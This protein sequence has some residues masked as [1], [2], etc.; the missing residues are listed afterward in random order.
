MFVAHLSADATTL[1]GSTYVGGTANDGINNDPALAHNYGDTF[2]GEIIVD[3]NGDPVVASTTSST[4]LP[5]VNASQ[6]SY[7]GGAQDGYCFRMD[8]SLS[9]LTWATYVGGSGADA[10]FG[11]QVDGNNELFVTG[12]TASA[13][14][15]MYGTPFQSLFSG[16]T[17][18]WVMHF[19]LGGLPLGSTFLGT[20]AY[21]Q[22]YFVQ[23]DQG[24]EVYLVGQTQGAYPVTPGKYTVPNSSQFI[25]KLNHDLTGSL[26]STVFGN[27]SNVQDLSP[28]AFLVSN[29][30]QIYFSGWG[31]TV[32][33]SAGS[34]SSTVVGMALTPDAYQSSTDGDDF[35]LMVLEP[36][37]TALNYATFFGGNL[38]SEHVDGGTSRFDKN[39]TIYQA[40]CAGCQDNDDFPT[41]PGAW[42]SDNA[43]VGCNLGVMKFDLLATVAIVGIDGP[44]TVCAPAVVQFTNNSVGGDSFEWDFGDGGTSNEAT[45]THL[46]TDPG[47]YTV[48]MRLS[49]S[50]SC[51]LADTAFLVLTVQ[52]DPAVTIDPVDPVCPGGSV[53]VQATG[54]LTYSWSPIAGVSDPNI[55]D[56]VITPPAPTTYQVVATGACGQDSAT[57]FIDVAQPTGSAGPDQQL[58]AGESVTLDGSGVGA[59]LWTPAITLSDPTAEDP[60][61]SPLDSMLY[62]LLITTAEGCT[63]NDTV[64]VVVDDG[65][66]VP[67][68]TD[69]LICSGATLQLHA[70]EG[71][72]YAWSPAAGLSDTTAPDP[73]VS[74]PASTWYVVNVSN[75]CGTI[76]DSAYVE[77]HQP[78]VIAGPDTTVCSGQPVQLVAS[79][80]ASYAWNPSASLSN[81]AIQMPVAIVNVPT[82]Y[83]VTMTDP[84][85]CVA[86]ASVLVDVHPVNAVHAYWDRV[87]EYGSSA[88]LLAIGNGT[89]T[90]TPAATLDSATTATPLASPLE[91]TTYTV[92]M[93][94]ANGCITTDAVTIIVPG[95]LF[96]PNTFTPNADGHNDAFGAWGTDITAID[97]QVFDRWG[98]LVWTA[99]SMDARWDGTYKGQ[100]APIDTY[101][102]KVHATEIAGE[103]HDRVGH[104]N[105]VR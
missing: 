100:Q 83:T 78:T 52:V 35:Y 88:P 103:V 77:I 7:G 40:V 24:D 53:Q 89:F 66:P 12:G 38:S 22:S 30:G 94:D 63:L 85:G 8:P 68:L 62:A 84:L 1:I 96:I 67:S 4:G 44:A 29:C 97:L 64:V 69:T 2:R 17:D 26:W 48:T 104:V 6:T 19:G 43:S 102:W 92:H 80:G 93:T 45:P 14:M 13:D 65:L 95:V 70:P 23:L 99:Q 87:I 55:A 59:F 60:V 32:N 5:T 56:P 3:A 18:A 61:A 98:K 81:A 58:C 73:W 90:W 86:Q 10:A 16:A 46:Y 28:T 72:S 75:L 47:V 71:R 49:D 21:D 42:S 101:V 36:D 37:A 33:A 105:L 57:V 54:G 50:L 20:A 27:G 34:F 39:G 79:E 74:P 31:G 15:P 25:H 82:T 41:T 91:A 9:T 11:T 76:Q 51:A